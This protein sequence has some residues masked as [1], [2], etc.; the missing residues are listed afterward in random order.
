MTEKLARLL[1]PGDLAVMADGRG[2]AVVQRVTVACFTDLV[3]PELH[4]FCT[5]EPAIKVEVYCPTGRPVEGARGL[6]NFV[7]CYHRPEDRVEIVQ[8]RNRTWS[9][10]KTQRR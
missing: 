2:L 7:T 4:K 6:I 3:D 8:G 9:N 5:K 10:N 1:R